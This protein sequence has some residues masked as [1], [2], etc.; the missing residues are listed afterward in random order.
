METKTSPRLGKW[1]VC[2]LAF[3]ILHHGAFST[4][5]ESK[6]LQVIKRHH[7]FSE[8]EVSDATSDWKNG[9]NE[10][11]FTQTYRE[12]EIWFGLLHFEYVIN[13]STT[14]SLAF[15]SMA[16]YIYTAPFLTSLFSS[17]AWLKYSTL[18]FVD[19][20]AL[21]RK[22]AKIAKATSVVSQEATAN[23]VAEVFADLLLK[24]VTTRFSRRFGAGRRQYRQMRA[25][26]IEL[27]RGTTAPTDAAEVV[28]GN[29][30][31]TMFT[32]VDSLKKN[33]FATVKNVV[34]HAF[35][36][37]LRGFSGMLE[38]EV[39]QG[40][41]AVSQQARNVLPFT[42]LFPGGILGRIMQKMMRSYVIFFHPVLANFKGLLSLFLGVLCKVRLPQLINA[43]FS[44][45]FRAKRRV[46]RFLNK[47]IS[48]VIGLRKD[49]TG[50]LLLEDMVK[51]WGAV[52]ITLLFQLHA[53]NIDSITRR[54]E[55]VE[56]ALPAGPGVW[57]LADGLFLGVKDFAQV[58]KD[59]VQRYLHLS[60]SIYTYCMEERPAYFSEAELA[61]FYNGENPQ[62]PARERLLRWCEKNRGYLAELER[63]HVGMTENFV[64][65][66]VKTLKMDFK[67]FE[68]YLSNIMSMFYEYTFSILE[69]DIVSAINAN[70]GRVS[71]QV[72]L[73]AVLR[74]RQ[75]ATPPPRDADMPRA[76]FRKPWMKVAVRELAHG[77]FHAAAGLSLHSLLG[78]QDAGDQ[79]V[80]EKSFNRLLDGAKLIR[81]SLSTILGRFLNSQ[82]II[83]R[84]QEQT[85][86]MRMFEFI[87]TCQNPDDPNHR[88]ACGMNVTT[89]IDE[90]KFVSKSLLSLNI[91]IV[92]D[93]RDLLLSEFLQ[94][95]QT[96]KIVDPTVVFAQ[97][98]AWLRQ[99]GYRPDGKGK[100]YLLYAEQIDE[101]GKSMAFS[102][103]LSKTMQDR[104]RFTRFDQ[105]DAASL[106]LFDVNGRSVIF[107]PK[108]SQQMFDRLRQI[109]PDPLDAPAVF[110]VI[111][112]NEGVLRFSQ[113]PG[114]PF[115]GALNYVDDRKE[116]RS[117]HQD[118]LAIKELLV[119][120][121]M[122]IKSRLSAEMTATL[123][124]V[125]HRYTPSFH[126]HSFSTFL[127]YMTP[128]M[129]FDALLAL[130]DSYEQQAETGVQ[131]E[132]R[133]YSFP[134]SFQ[135][136]KEVVFN[137]M[138][139]MVLRMHSLDTADTLSIFVVGL[140]HYAYQKIQKN[141]TGKTLVMNHFQRGLLHIMQTIQADTFREK[142]PE[143]G[144]LLEDN[145]E[146]DD[147]VGLKCALFRFLKLRSLRLPERDVAPGE[148]VSQ[149]TLP[150][151]RAY[152]NGAVE[153][154]DRQRTTQTSWAQFLN[155]KSLHET[156]DLY[157]ETAG[158]YNYE[159]L[160][161]LIKTEPVVDMEVL[162]QLRSMMDP[163]LGSIIP[164]R[165]TE[166]T[167]N[168]LRNI[169]DNMKNLSS[170]MRHKL[171]K[172]M[173]QLKGRVLSIAGH[174]SVPKALR[175]VN[176]INGNHFFGALEHGEFRAFP[177]TQM[178]PEDFL[179][180]ADLAVYGR[181]LLVLESVPLYLEHPKQMSD[182]VSQMRVIP[183]VSPECQ[184]LFSEIE[185][186][187]RQMS[188]EDVRAAAGWLLSFNI[189]KGLTGSTVALALLALAGV[190]SA[191]SQVSHQEKV[192]ILKVMDADTL[193]F[194]K[195]ILVMPTVFR[196]MAA[197][198]DEQAKELF[199]FSPKA[200]L[201]A[202]YRAAVKYLP[203]R[204]SVTVVD[205]IANIIDSR[206]PQLVQM[207]LGRVE[208]LPGET[209]QEAI[210]R[211]LID[212]IRNELGV[213]LE[214]ALKYWSRSQIMLDK[215]LPA[216]C[217]LMI[218]LK[219]MREKRQHETTVR[220]LIDAMY[221]N[222]TPLMEYLNFI[223]NK[224]ANEYERHKQLERIGPV[225]SML[226]VA[227]VSGSLQ[228]DAAFVGYNGETEIL[229]FHSRRTTRVPETPILNACLQATA[230]IMN[231]K[232]PKPELFQ[233]NLSSYFFAEWL[234]FLEP[235]RLQAYAEAYRT[236]GGFQDISYDTLRNLSS[237]YSY[238]DLGDYA[239][240][241]RQRSLY[242]PA[243]IVKQASF[244]LASG[245]K[246]IDGYG[247]AML[248]ND[249]AERVKKAKISCY[250]EALNDYAEY[251]QKSRMA[252][253]MTKIDC[254]HSRLM[255]LGSLGFSAAS[256]TAEQ[257]TRIIDSLDN[258]MAAKCEEM[259]TALT[260]STVDVHK[261]KEQAWTYL[262]LPHISMNNSS[263]LRSVA[264]ML[265]GLV[266]D[267]VAKRPWNQV[268][269]RIA[270]ER[271]RQ[272]W[273]RV[274][275]ISHR[276]PVYSSQERPYLFNPYGIVM[277]FLL[278]VKT[279]KVQKFRLP[280]LLLL[281]RARI[282]VKLPFMKR[283]TPPG[284]VDYKE[285]A[286]DLKDAFFAP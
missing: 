74:R 15:K 75:Q 246:T 95:D 70:Q 225:M 144:F 269:D 19:K 162:T 222:G 125:L 211:T 219:V 141:R 179:K 23:R 188:H 266:L 37:G 255:D 285:T 247:M 117:I 238:Y 93:S 139:T 170:G 131:L 132:R 198:P 210:C 248:M 241:L 272:V 11:S 180:A 26:L 24:R 256:L 119:S 2:L 161:R 181:T 81:S 176:V 84:A 21:V 55:N 155:Y 136:F 284:L 130:A 251:T 182:I 236:A 115:E 59:Y 228:L 220:A 138:N 280:K 112:L 166:G 259:Y 154:L 250:E 36:N 51:G 152:L 234:R 22:L 159:E 20:Q 40:C 52:M 172:A 60:I 45:I 29:N 85:T 168:V 163:S 190:P 270:E 257:T 273:E 54:G 283:M 4:F 143:C 274:G 99:K 56:S 174:S 167:A 213:S 217:I 231:P 30:T 114:I 203:L 110:E 92:T 16:Q 197:I 14:M 224:G 25:E 8:L 47:F 214:E 50:Q 149:M 66:M 90:V 39:N 46:G 146:I 196:H 17:N 230:K 240:S 78:G 165:G 58:F 107:T 171:R 34:A 105:E 100:E 31:Q 237:V 61:D 82:A 96:K 113:N 18:D 229:T 27:I 122:S 148:E 218:N 35:E 118:P 49:I 223:A 177:D 169:L 129:F 126:R 252:Q 158:A 263:R 227:A 286:A 6:S 142:F 116:L 276:T 193:R 77:F 254:V 63:N 278:Y 33:P 87:N 178:P 145:A 103:T 156:S 109:H 187:V 242:P 42:N 53:V 245:D 201:M 206:I 160:E 134:V 41:F 48:K 262:T 205:A 239:Y 140:I 279:N 44:A 9:G 244:S 64:A 80:I 10:I 157:K 192:G 150:M 43:I 233:L 226:H 104:L 120:Q 260:G 282:L 202:V 249:L 275:D 38:W 5:S 147:V 73:E 153:Y 186:M 32:W 268:S 1:V 215:R 209:L 185:A 200:S 97:W 221:Y 88:D 281:K 189:G 175:F 184:E 91:G 3:M 265:H 28:L 98:E 7:N 106:R 69:S 127:Q 264:T 124:M 258:V 76:M 164:P 79:A 65:H 83:V 195:K 128:K 67:Y 123:M 121:L 62:V 243:E 137:S 267:I 94:T 199:R 133:L 212:G 86:R 151:V 68:G 12:G 13:A 101:R 232:E 57:A 108:N 191:N 277:D 135:T 271:A 253:E 216:A 208:E 204:E 89:H 261:L 111:E 183:F 173:G 102:D 72:E 235:S 194:I 71:Y 207:Q